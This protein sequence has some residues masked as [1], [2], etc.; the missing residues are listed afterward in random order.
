MGFTTFTFSKPDI[1]AMIFGLIG[2][3]GVSYLAFYI[4]V[5]KKRKPEEK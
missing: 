2:L 3:V 4:E 1:I 5:R